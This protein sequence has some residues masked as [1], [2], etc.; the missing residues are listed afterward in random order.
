MILSLN[1]YIFF[2]KFEELHNVIRYIKY[3]ECIYV[4]LSLIMLYLH[5]GVVYNVRVRS[6]V[7]CLRFCYLKSV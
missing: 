3:D 1:F 5:F 6:I 2:V 7:P 4:I